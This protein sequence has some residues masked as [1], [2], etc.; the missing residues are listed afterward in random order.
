MQ[1]EFVELQQKTAGLLIEEGAES[2]L[3]KG[4]STI[5]PSPIAVL[6][7]YVGSTYS[8]QQKY[9]NIM[10]DL[11]NTKTEEGTTIESFLTKDNLNY[12]SSLVGIATR[13]EWVRIH[14]IT[15]R[16]D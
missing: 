15:A 7:A 4:L 10:I 5:A 2:P 16:G 12:I 6:V 3:A 14:H 13:A 8:N 1:D 11:V 9:A